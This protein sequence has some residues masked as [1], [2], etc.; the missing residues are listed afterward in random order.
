MISHILDTISN[1]GIADFNGE[2]MDVC[3]E[4]KSS[5]DTSQNEL[6]VHLDSFL[7]HSDPAFHNQRINTPWLP[8]KQV[9]REHVSIHDA[10]DM[11]RD[12]AKSWRKRISLCI[13]QP[14]LP[15]P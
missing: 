1:I 14:D 8:K 6:I 9:I 12:I 11:A 5:Y 10:G 4:T 15:E 3:S 7:R 2:R 13:P